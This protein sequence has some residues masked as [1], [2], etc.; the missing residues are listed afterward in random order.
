MSTVSVLED[1]KAKLEQELLD[2]RSDKEISSREGLLI[3]QCSCCRDTPPPVC[4]FPSIAP[5]VLD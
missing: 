5:T 2:A 3:Y 1:Q 4:S